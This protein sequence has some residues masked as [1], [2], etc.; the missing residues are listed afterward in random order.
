MTKREIDLGFT[1]DISCP[2]EMTDSE[3]LCELKK[4][5]LG[6][7][8]ELRTEGDINLD[9]I[10]KTTLDANLAILR[11]EISIDGSGIH[12]AVKGQSSSNDYKRYISYA[13]K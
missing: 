12:P 1:L 5:I 8:S 3:V 13:V 2:E 10:F 4:A 7:S 9:F 11:S 6:R